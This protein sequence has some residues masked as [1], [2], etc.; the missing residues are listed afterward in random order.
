VRAYNP[1][2]LHSLQQL[3]GNAL[4]ERFTLMVNHV[5]SSEAAAVQR[6][7]PHAGRCIRLHI[8]GWPSALPP[9]PALAFVV[10]PAGLVEW[11][12][13]ETTQVAD[14]QLSVDASNPARLVAQGLAGQRPP[15]D[16][17]GDARLAT[18]VSWLMDNLRWEAQDD[19]A[20][21]VGPALANELARVGA[22][23]AAGV[24]HAVRSLADLA[25][26]LRSE[27]PVR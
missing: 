15:V 8:I 24:R 3:F 7:R 4:I 13:P 5:I 23:L 14:L 2:M 26:R 17:A 16:V 1:C 20:R 18:D 9:L 12:G 6:L 19:L 21:I 11:C 25:E 27:Q 22:M 10:T